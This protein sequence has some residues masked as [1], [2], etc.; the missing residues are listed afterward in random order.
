[1]AC[2]F[3][4]FLNTTGGITVLS[5]AALFDIPKPK[6]QRSLPLVVSERAFT[7]MLMMVRSAIGTALER[8]SVLRAV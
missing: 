2:C 5:V 6:R 7:V 1:M 3:F 4:F 8:E